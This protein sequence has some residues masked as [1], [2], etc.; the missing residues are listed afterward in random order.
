[1]VEPV[2][3][4]P[5][6]RIGRGL[7]GEDRSSVNQPE[8]GAKILPNIQLPVSLLTVT[9]RGRQNLLAILSS[10]ETQNRK[11]WETMCVSFLVRPGFSGCDF[12]PRTQVGLA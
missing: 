2:S 10:L 9:E 12:R 4:G 11:H 8:A 3:C 6:L 1:M 7:R 5:A